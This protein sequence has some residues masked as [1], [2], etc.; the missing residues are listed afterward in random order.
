MLNKL[1]FY[2]Y[3]FWQMLK[4]DLLIYKRS[5][6][7]Q[8]IDAA[9]WVSCNISVATYIF[10]VLGMPLTFG[11]LIA[12]S[13]IAS[14]AVWA[15]WSF[16]SIFVSDLSGDRKINYFLTLPIP[17]WLIFVKQ[18]AAYAIR[19]SIVYGAL[20][21]FC[22]L[23]MPMRLDLSSFSL[24]KYIVIL[25]VSNLCTSF[26]AQFMGGFIK[27]LLYLDSISTRV[28]MPLWTLGCSQFAFD[29][30]YKMNPIVAQIDLLNPVIYIME[31]MRAA[32]FNE[33]TQHLS[34]SICLVALCLFC[35]FFVLVSSW[36]LKKRLDF[37]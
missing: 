10:P 30:L 15:I 18:A 20:L 3:V 8:L 19:T 36:R 22:K 4:V 5:I 14:G 26:L 7:S 1:K 9:V 16:N 34:F 28:I 21:P 13:S 6:V 17:S 35:I 25:L 31:G 32:I 27:N 33:N 11:S 37:V 12:A 29:T 23:L 24:I 2:A